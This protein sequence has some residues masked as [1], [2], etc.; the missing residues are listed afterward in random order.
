MIENR[1]REAGAAGGGDGAHVD[2]PRHPGRPQSR[3][4]R[5]LRRRLIADGGKRK[6]DWYQNR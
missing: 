4:D 3:D 2:Q 6:E 1:L 5:R